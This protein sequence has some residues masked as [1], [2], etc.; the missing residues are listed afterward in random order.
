MCERLCF[1]LPKG[2]RSTTHYMSSWS[3]FSW[4]TRKNVMCPSPLVLTQHQTAELEKLLVSTE[5]VALFEKET[6]Q[7]SDST[8]WH[9]LRKSRLTASKIGSI[10]KRRSDFH[11]LCDQL[12]CNIRCTSAMK[13]GL[14]REPLA[15][16]VYATIMDSR[17][18][19]YS[20]GLVISPYTPW[21]A[22]SPDRKV[23]CSDRTPPFC[24][25]EIKCP[26]S[27]NLDTWAVLQ[28]MK[29]NLNINWRRT[30]TT[31]TRCNV[32]WQWQAWT[33]V[34]SWCIWK[35]ETYIWKQSTLT[36]SFGI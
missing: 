1:I 14:L 10:C 3:R 23:F 19:V 25:L 33:G 5:Q 29:I 12:K 13:E 24:L 4:T 7:Q 18:N 11:K 9:R 22:A 8:L 20:C 27:H 32:S 31:I 16:A 35:T 30:T 34:T 28:Q 6:Q 17:V 2:N 15:T 26:Q 21:L 36:A